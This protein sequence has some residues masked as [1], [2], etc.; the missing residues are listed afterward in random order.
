MNDEGED[1][2]E[3]EDVIQNVTPPYCEHPPNPYVAYVY[4]HI[5]VSLPACD[6]YE[7]IFH[8]IESSIHEK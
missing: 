6:I 8:E 2:G 1:E 7:K 3:D 5:P 4:I